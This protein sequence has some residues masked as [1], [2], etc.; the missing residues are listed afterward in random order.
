MIRTWRE[1]RS[2]DAH[3]MYAGVVRAR[4]D[5]MRYKSPKRI[6]NRYV[7][8]RRSRKLEFER[9]HRRCR[10]RIQVCAKARGFVEIRRRRRAEHYRR[11]GEAL[12][13]LRVLSDGTDVHNRFTGSSEREHA[14]IT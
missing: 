13:V 14:G 10:V 5:R 3:V 4:I 11:D 6:D 2:I 7:D 12:E 8:R 9:C 1:L